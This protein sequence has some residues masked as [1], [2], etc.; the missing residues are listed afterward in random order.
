MLIELKLTYF[1]TI[2]GAPESEGVKPDWVLTVGPATV[3]GAVE[4]EDSGGRYLGVAVV[5]SHPT[6][7]AARSGTAL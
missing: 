4:A 7:F 2:G 5:L 3:R 1:D 6:S